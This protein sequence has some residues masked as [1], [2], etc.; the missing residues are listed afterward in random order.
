MAMLPPPQIGPFESSDQAVDALQTWARSQGYAVVRHKPSNYINNMPRRYEVVCA[1]GG[2]GYVPEGAGLRE[3]G[4][5]KTG[6]P[7][8]IKFVRRKVE[9]DDLWGVEIMHGEHNH[10]ATEPRSFPEHR[11]LPLDQHEHVTGW[12]NFIGL[13]ARTIREALVVT[14]DDCLATEKDINNHIAK[15][16]LKEL[17]THT[18]TQA[19]CHYLQEKGIRHA[20]RLDDDNH[21]EW[22]I[23]LVDKGLETWASCSDVMM[24]D[25]TYK[26]NRFNLKLLEICG[27]TSVGTVFPVA[28]ALMPQESGRAF[29][30]C[31]GHLKA[32][33]A[34]YARVI[35][36][37]VDSLFP[38]VIITDKDASERVGIRDIFPHCQ[39]QLCTLHLT[40]N[41]ISAIKRHWIGPTST[42][43]ESLRVNDLINEDPDE[44]EADLGPPDL[45]ALPAL[46]DVDFA[47]A[48]RDLL[49][50]PTPD[51]FDKVWARIE[52]TYRRQ[53]N[54]LDYFGDHLLPVRAQWAKAYTKD[55]RNYGHTTTS[56]IE[57]QHRSGK[58]FLP[59]STATLPTLVNS[60]ERQQESAIRRYRDQCA[61]ETVRHMNTYRSTL[62]SEVL[63]RVSFKSLKLVQKQYNMAYSARLNDPGPQGWS[64]CSGSFSRQYGLPCKHMILL[65]LRLEVDGSNKRIINVMQPLPLSYWDPYWYLPNDLQNYNPYHRIKDPHVVDNRVRARRVAP[66]NTVL[67]QPRGSQNPSSQRPRE[68]RIAT[69]MTFTHD[70]VEMMITRAL[71]RVTQSS[72]SPPTT[73]APGPS[74]GSQPHSE[75]V[76]QM[77]PSPQPRPCSLVH[78]SNAAQRRM[79]RVPS[80]FEREEPLERPTKRPRR[81]LQQQARNTRSGRAR[82]TNL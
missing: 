66:N 29:S 45:P 68:Q 60:L 50:A 7:F 64:D 27:I 48:W 3:A 12:R 59:D 77:P 21:L 11:K 38:K 43:L 54:L 52:E 74:Q 63:G 5:R 19:V 30:W 78:R 20:K 9:Y 40:R 53:R 23:V 65:F 81:A 17:G 47:R 32:W 44:F 15:A 14:A 31:L 13:T 35:S 67:P 37:A 70:E 33:M 24:M 57:A 55:Y 56:P 49:N 61:R 36:I 34:H 71:L 82:Q 62:F 41:L 42:E 1:R 73:E 26:T 4:T 6:C 22:L 28:W 69:P 58:S 72:Q 8:K 2:K 18:A 10:E 46:G 51:E 75:I 79:K 25:L 39:K 76:V 80:Q 16:H